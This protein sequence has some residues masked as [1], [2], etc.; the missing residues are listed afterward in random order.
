M[1][2]TPWPN[3]LGFD[4]ASRPEVDIWK[5]ND[6]F[7]VFT[8]TKCLKVPYSVTTNPATALQITDEHGLSRRALDDMDP[9]E[10]EALYQATTPMQRELF[11]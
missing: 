3:N 10:A 8:E 9:R 11:G 6:G 1:Q 5:H 2:I 4:V 7:R